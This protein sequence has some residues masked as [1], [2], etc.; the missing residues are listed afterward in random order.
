MRLCRIGLAAFV[1]TT[2]WTLP[3]VAADPA[4]E[5]GGRIEAL[6][7]ALRD[8]ALQGQAL[9]RRAVIR[10]FAD[11]IFDFHESARRVLGTHWATRTPEEQERFVRAFA[12]L[13]DHAYLRR[14]DEYDGERVVM[15]GHSVQGDQATVRAQIVARDG[16]TIPVDFL[17][18]H[19]SGA[20]WRA[21][22]VNVGGMSLVAS[23]RAQFN[24]IIRS[25][26]YEELLKRLEV[27]SVSAQQ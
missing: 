9:E 23:Y 7:R 6:F 20:H 4:T 16:D 27:K 11:A 14:V 1:A 24:R 26:S 15:V 10:R 8:P 22:D 19:G 18:V 21:Y 25:G 5:L 17:M 2:L 12:G 3:A 13:I